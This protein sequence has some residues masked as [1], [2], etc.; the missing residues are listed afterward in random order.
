MEKFQVAK[1]CLRTHSLPLNGNNEKGSCDDKRK[2]YTFKSIDLRVI[3]GDMYDR[4]EMFNLELI[5]IAHDDDREY[6][7]DGSILAQAGA[8]PSDR[9][10]NIHLSGLDVINGSYDSK[11]RTNTS[12]TVIASYQFYT[13]ITKTFTNHTLTFRKKQTH[14]LNFYY[15][16]IADSG[17]PSSPDAFPNVTYRFNIYGII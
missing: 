11:G 1:L 17:E 4:Y 8:L 14:N 16:T 15:S 12:S 5:G 9:T 6:N 10:V 2:N 13:D 7:P 3:L